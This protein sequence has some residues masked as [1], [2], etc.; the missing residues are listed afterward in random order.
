MQPKHMPPSRHTCSAWQPAPPTI[1][2]P[3]ALRSATD[4]QGAETTCN[5]IKAWLDA[6]KADTGGS[7]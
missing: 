1:Q 4:C 2:I 6:T 5:E 7:C 3:A